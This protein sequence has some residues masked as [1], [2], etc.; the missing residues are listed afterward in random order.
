MK[1]KYIFFSLLLGLP[2]FLS[3]QE[4]LT[5]SQI[6]TRLATAIDLF[7]KEKYA[8]AQKQF[9]D[10]VTE[11]GE[12]YSDNRTDAEYYAAVCAI[13]LFNNDAESRIVHFIN[14]YPES[15]RLNIAYYYLATYL[16]S[17]QKYG[18]CI[19]WF[20]KVDIDG[21]D[22]SLLAEYYF[23]FGHSYFVKEKYDDAESLLGEIKDSQTKYAV[24]ATYFYAHI[25][26][27]KRNYQTALEHFEELRENELFKAFVPYYIAQI[28]YL[29]KKYDKV[30][31]YAPALLDSSTVKRRTEL[32]RLV[33]DAYY[34]MQ[35][36]DK[37][38]PYMEKYYD[39][40]KDDEGFSRIDNFELGYLYYMN[41]NYK[42][43]TVFFEQTINERDSL[44]QNSAYLLASSYIRL[45]Q[46]EKALN[47]FFMASQY[48]FY[49][50]IKEDAA[51]NYAKLSYELSYAP[52]T[53]SIK[54]L[55]NF[56]KDYPKSSHLDEMYGYLGQAMYSSKDYQ[57][58][59]E[60]LD[61]I[62]TKYE[63]ANEIYQR[64]AFYR[65]MEYFKKLEYGKAVEMYDK[66]LEESKIDKK[67]AALSLYWKA[68]ALYRM[69]KYDESLNWY[70]KFILAMGA[71]D[72]EEYKLAHYNIGYCYFKKQAY[73]EASN[74]FRKF[75]DYYPNAKTKIIADAYNRIG[76]YFYLARQFDIAVDYCSKA[77]DI[78]KFDVD[79]SLYQE[80]LCYG[81][82]S[83]KE[84]QKI[85]VLTQLINDFGHSPYVDDAIY[86]RGETYT[87]ME[88]YKMAL[89]DF[90][91]LTE[92]YP[93]SSYVP[94]AYIKKG[95][96]YYNMNQYEQAKN[97][98][99]YVVDHYKGTEYME[100]AI[101]MLKS[102]YVDK[103]A[104]EDY[105]D[106]L[107][108]EGLKDYLSQSEEDSLL[109][110][111]AE[112]VY[113]SGDCQMAKPMFEKY[114]TKF[115]SGKFSV[116]AHFY[117]AEC[118]N[119]TKDYD[120]AM[121]HYKKVIKIP[122]KFTELALMR[123]STIAYS[124]EKY[125][126]ALIYYTRLYNEAQMP[127]YIEMALRKMVELNYRLKHY[128]EAKKNA[129]ALLKEKKVTEAEKRRAHYIIAMSFYNMGEKAT[130]VDE[131]TLLAKEP[132]TEEGAEAN[133]RL[134]E[135]GYDQKKY[136]EVE[137]K[138][139]LFVKTGT[140]YQYWLGK[141]FILLAKVYADKENYT[142]ARATLESIIQHYKI[143]DDGIKEEAQ[144]EMKMLDE[145]IK[146]KENK[147]KQTEENINIDYST[148]TDSLLFK[149]DSTVIDTIKIENHE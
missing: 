4:T 43:A 127:E 60:A 61:K 146:A 94:L 19:K 104:V 2:L 101:Q 90:D 27:V 15:S 118:D 120:D 38:L 21:L 110:T 83:G 115:S 113:M 132:L 8:A 93:N 125:D 31:E 56:I 91:L 64:V 63:D 85:I 107:S 119:N 68:E 34:R 54:I 53:K 106:Y 114:L 20:K 135:W 44:S 10:I 144:T 105:S 82:V 35:Q 59:M 33:A 36:Y 126:T 84:S 69:K 116:N 98:C 99:Q 28:Y 96:I 80:A 75:V 32:T 40:V 140:P 81:F 121:Q 108:Q 148:K 62:K 45:S 134:I 51:F 24:P 102:I 37:A 142:Q 138:V 39:L 123:L 48:D 30:I 50:N 145:A 6:E 23:K 78:N 141:S 137:S 55:M 26:Y 124:E 136:D 9:I 143:E 66:S 86:L 76:D 139:Y 77:V 25:Q 46:K 7:N 129:I 147:D 71:Y 97:S 17:Q 92:T 13:K 79:Y 73:K 89:A 16:Y 41:K 11:Y 42:K 128:D 5:H 58:A 1:I 103:G 117:I 131:F 112:K 57:G 130:A 122:S 87:N 70:K 133:Y 72:M 3:A 95:I 22:N 47:A 49:P 67:I 111:S 65:G 100:E 149:Q 74:W 52:F 12:T 14:Y 109:Y 18:Q 29:Q 88:E